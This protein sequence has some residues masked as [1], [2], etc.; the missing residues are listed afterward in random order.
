MKN[1]ILSY[2]EAQIWYLFHSGFAVKTA[3]HFIIFDY[4]L[5]TPT[6]QSGCLA[7]GVICPEEIKDRNVLVFSSH[8]HHDHFNPVIFN[9]RKKIKR[10]HYLLSSDIEIEDGRNDVLFVDKHHNYRIGDVQVE[11]FGST[12]LGVSFLVGVDGLTLFH[13]GDL[14]WWH[15]KGES[16]TWNQQMKIDYQKEINLLKGKKIDLAFIPV[17]PRLEEYYSLGLDCFMNTV[18]AAKVFPMHFGNDYSIFDWLKHGNTKD[19]TSKIMHITHRG[20]HF[21]HKA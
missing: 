8:S 1:D 4:Y 16:E 6:R 7:A 14:N 15:W 10:I 2:H 9:W 11:V 20:Q 19:Y 21:S 3:N 18:G 13:A 12:D 17:D 5:N